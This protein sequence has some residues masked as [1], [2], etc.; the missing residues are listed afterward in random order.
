MVTRTETRRSQTAP[1]VPLSFTHGPMTT[2]P[3][4]QAIAA[5]AWPVG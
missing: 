2:S 1:A 3:I 4:R 5:I